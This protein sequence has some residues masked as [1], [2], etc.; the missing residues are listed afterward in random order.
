MKKIVFDV[1]AEK[2]GALT[3]LQQFYDKAVGDVENLWI[4][5]VSLPEFKSKDNIR[6]LRYPWVK[7]SWLHRLFFDYFFAKRIV[8]K[9]KPDEI[10]SLQNVVVSGVAVRQTIYLH[11]PLP[12]C[13]V[14]FKIL[15]EPILWLY[16]NPISWMIIRSLKKASSVIVQTEW[17]RQACESKTGISRDFISVVQPEIKLSPEN[18]FVPKGEPC[19]FYPA[20]DAFYK[21]HRIILDALKKIKN[22][23]QKLNIN[24]TFTLVGDETKKIR[25]LKKSVMRE[26]LPI[27]FVGH[28]TS[29]EVF[30][31][32]ANSIL[33]FPS[34]V[35][36]YG[37]PL[38]E[39]MIANCPIIASDC[40]FSHEILKEY[41]LVEYFNPFSVDELVE[42]IN[43]FSRYWNDI[44]ENKIELK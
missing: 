8:K 14:R 28:L 23:N 4:F 30:E 44:I 34:Y 32:Y 39:A 5:V 20:G 27:S 22:N 2:G 36:T 37:L 29:N 19:F 17:M 7:K 25:E 6:V 24:V 9:L 1:P 43:R 15:D 31:Y 18:Y 3:I 16:Q 33:L 40:S 21:N 26:K 11:Q 38:K 12:F 35:E 10:I 13:D 42:C 41:R